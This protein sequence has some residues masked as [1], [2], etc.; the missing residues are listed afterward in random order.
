MKR[1]LFDQVSQSKFHVGIT[2]HKARAVLFLRLDGLITPIMACQHHP[3]GRM[4]TMD[5]HVHLS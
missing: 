3:A 2:L 4:L 5:R 1:T